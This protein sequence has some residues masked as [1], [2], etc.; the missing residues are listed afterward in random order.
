[1]DRRKGF[2]GTLAFC[3]NMY[4]SWQTVNGL[5]Y[6]SNEHFFQASKMARPEDHERVRLSMSPYVA[7]QL[8]AQL[9]QRDNW[10]NIKDGVMLLGLR[11]K[12]RQNLAL[13]KMLLDTGQAWLIETNYWHDNEWGVCTCAKC[14]RLSPGHNKLG[15]MLE[16][17][18][19][20]LALL[21]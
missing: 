14:R 1:M 20:E 15:L 10:D 18:R 4:L 13:S 2:S 7:K 12:F 6:H 9:R 8:S 3:S 19:S 11:S 21:L 16:G 17:V 5:L